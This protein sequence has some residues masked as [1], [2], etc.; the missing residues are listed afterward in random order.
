MQL[1][2]YTV[3][4]R[5]LTVSLVICPVTVRYAH[6]GIS[7]YLENDSSQQHNL[8]SMLPNLKPCNKKIFVFIFEVSVLAFKIKTIQLENIKI[9]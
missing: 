9:G 1:S 2:Q 8:R 5:M 6:S 4:E 3:L 7:N